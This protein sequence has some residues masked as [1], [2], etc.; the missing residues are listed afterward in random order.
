MVCILLGGQQNNAY[1][2]NAWYEYLDAPN[3]EM[4]KNTVELRLKVMFQFLFQLSEYH[5]V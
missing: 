2:T 5:L 1:W 3:D 4:K